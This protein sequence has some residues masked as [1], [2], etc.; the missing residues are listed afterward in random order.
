MKLSSLIQEEQILLND[1]KIS[2]DREL[3]AKASEM[4]SDQFKI[5]KEKVLS[6]FMERYELGHDILEGLYA[7]PHGRLENFSD[8]II[9]IIKTKKTI[10][11]ANGEANFFFFL[12]TSNTGSNS[13]LKALAG[14]AKIIKG[15]KEKLQ[16]VKKTE[17][18]H[19]ILS[20]SNIKLEESVTVAEIMSRD[21]YKAKPEQTISHILNIMK[22]KNLKYMP[23]VN[24]QDEYIG[25]LDLLDILDIAYPSYLFLMN[26]LSFL[27]NLR[28]FED[29][30]A[31]ENDVLVKD[32][33]KAGHKRVIRFDASIVELGFV[34]KKEHMHYIT[35]VDDKDKVIG[36]VSMRDMLNKIIRA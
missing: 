28:S 3:F 8:L 18:L 27:N 7:I 31:K 10:K 36:I 29:F 23:V 14:I 20:E 30:I 2:T 15:N 26:S 13:Y 35:V 9:L 34:M 6:A 33:F 5:P 32:V 11:F 12:M 4:I 16:N 19:K 1:D 22:V 17:E 25:K 24:E 21:V